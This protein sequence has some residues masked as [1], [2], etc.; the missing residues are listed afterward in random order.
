M[1][2]YGPGSTR[3]G[4]VN[5]IPVGGGNSQWGAPSNHG[6]K[7]GYESGPGS[8][9]MS[10]QSKYD[11]Q[12]GAD[13]PPAMDLATA[14]NEVHNGV[15]EVVL[16]IPLDEV[17]MVMGKG[18][19][20]IKEMQRASLCKM[21]L[22]QNNEVA[23]GSRERGFFLNGTLPQ[24]HEA[25]KLIFERLAE[26]RK[27]IDERLGAS[28]NFD[29]SRKKLLKWVIEA[30]KCGRI[31]G[32]AGRIARQ[33][34][35]DTGSHIQIGPESE[36]PP[37]SGERVVFITGDD[38]S[39]ER[40]R[41]EVE[42]RVG[43]RPPSADQLNLSPSGVKYPVPSRS[44][45]AILG[46]GGNEIKRI[47]QMSRARVKVSAE[48]KLGV[49]ERIVFIDGNPEQVEEARKLIDERVEAWRQQVMAE[50][51]GPDCGK[52]EVCLKMAIPVALVG[53]LIG[54]SATN[55]KQIS[56]MHRVSCSVNQDETTYSTRVDTRPLIMNGKLENVLG[57]QEDV[58]VSLKCAPQHLKEQAMQ[59]PVGVYPR[60]DRSMGGPPGHD[61]NQQMHNPYGMPPGPQ[62]PGMGPPP[63]MQGP[64]GMPPGPGMPPP[65]TQGMQGP[66]Q[67]PPG[68]G[69]PPM[70]AYDSQGMPMG[71]MG[72]EHQPMMMGG[73]PMMMFD[74]QGM[75]MMM[76]D[77]P[78]PMGMMMGMQPPPSGSGYD[79]IYSITPTPG[80]VELSVYPTVLTHIV[81]K[82]GSKIRELTNASGCMIK[83]Q[84]RETVIPGQHDRKLHLAG[85]PVQVEKGIALVG[86][87]IGELLD[88]YPEMRGGGPIRGRNNKF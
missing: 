79:G 77:G 6:V 24:L 11:H 65:N 64:P 23:E 22:Q 72:Q 27:L 58:L 61:Q 63:G 38:E 55:I 19:N 31:I 35:D 46:T 67:G 8:D 12:L 60:G 34:F 20:V 51:E 86:Q 15:S 68:M 85:D 26:E 43:G 32:T 81:G 40:A 1:D 41:R 59:P 2:H 25:Q 16:L 84:D 36:L 80:G 47:T 42:A 53:Y 14:A 10:S 37:G 48:T 28:D 18:G 49:A 4:P 57:A 29:L 66:P 75:P 9:Q 74:Q 50:G 52:N 83:A 13:G 78:P 73:P 87:F 56:A 62:G 71:M 45:G 69:P 70:G 82:G 7:R 17:G 54:R 5:D 33:I 39:N 76:M 21:N 3:A 44:V 88:T 30:S